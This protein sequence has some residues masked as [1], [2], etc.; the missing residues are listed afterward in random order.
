MQQGKLTWHDE[1]YRRDQV[2]QVT[3]SSKTNLE[4]TTPTVGEKR[5]SKSIQIFHDAPTP[6]KVKA[7]QYHQV[8]WYH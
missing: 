6:T 8:R 1:F 2:I 7:S 3:V 4:Q 5:P